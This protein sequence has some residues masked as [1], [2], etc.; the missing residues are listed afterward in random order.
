MNSTEKKGIT[1]NFRFFRPNFQIPGSVAT[2]L[3]HY[4]YCLRIGV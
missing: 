1:Q 4:R 3:L 2:L